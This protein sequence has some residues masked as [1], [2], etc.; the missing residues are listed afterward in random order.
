[1]ELHLSTG[2]VLPFDCT[3]EN[4]KEKRKKRS[5]RSQKN[6]NPQPYKVLE[7]GLMARQVAD[8]FAWLLSRNFGFW[9]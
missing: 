1:M 8:R 5:E 9:G 7:G 2:L 4:L 6:W 3:L